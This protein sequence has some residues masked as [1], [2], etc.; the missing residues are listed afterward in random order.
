[1]K[2]LIL[3]AALALGL[4]VPSLA[5]AQC[6]GI[7]CTVP[8]SGL[9]FIARNRTYTASSVALVPAA[10]ATD[11]WCINGST[12]KTVSIRQIVIAG[13]A[14]TAITTPV[15]VNLN[16][17][18]DTAGTPATG[19]ALPVPVPVN[20]ADSAATATTTAWTANGTVNDTTPSL[21]A[22]LTPTF[23]VTTSAN[24]ESQLLF[25]TSVDNFNKGIDIPP[26]ATVVQQVCLNMNGKSVSSGLL[27]ITVQWTESP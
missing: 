16:H 9:A 12:T 19:L 25:G 26:A 22:V 23:Q 17:S 11:F 3:L 24:Q 1:V 8:Q 21:V 10:S 27:N 20:S 15:L 6:P 4:L 14:G 7:N 18:L 13:T 2:K 5:L